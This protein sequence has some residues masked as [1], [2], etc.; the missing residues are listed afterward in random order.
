MVDIDTTTLDGKTT[1]KKY[2]PVYAYVPFI[3]KKSS[4]ITDYPFKVGDDFCCL[5]SR[6]FA[7]Q[8]TRYLRGKR[9]TSNCASSVS[10]FFNGKEHGPHISASYAVC[11]LHTQTTRD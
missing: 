1:K 5:K 9:R 8:I 2:F 6:G 10:A 4:R 3:A 7:V 11:G